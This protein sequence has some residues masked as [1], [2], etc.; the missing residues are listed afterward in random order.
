GVAGRL[1]AVHRRRDRRRAPDALER[2]GDARVARRAGAAMTVGT[3][4]TT[5]TVAEAGTWRGEK[6][7]TAAFILT[8]LGA[9]LIGALLGPFQALN[10]GGINLYDDVL[11][12]LRSYYQGLTLHGVLNVLVFTTFFN[13]G[14][15]L[16]F[17]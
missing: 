7:V 8:G 11:P 6:A 2:R 17:P 9:L 13:A 15:L 3:I 10:Y 16:Y 5:T 1:R 12:F 14:V 4:P